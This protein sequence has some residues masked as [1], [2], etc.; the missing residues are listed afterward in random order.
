MRAK[1]KENGSIL[2]LTAETMEDEVLIEKFMW[3]HKLYDWKDLLVFLQK[4]Y[5]HL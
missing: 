1:V 2:V 3:V 4:K 5:E